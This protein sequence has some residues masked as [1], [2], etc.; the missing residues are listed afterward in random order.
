[1]DKVEEKMENLDVVNKNA[2]GGKKSKEKTECCDTQLEVGQIETICLE[3]YC[4]L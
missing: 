3:V 2:K 4:Q 1:M